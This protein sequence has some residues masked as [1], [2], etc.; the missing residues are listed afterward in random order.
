[1]TFSIQKAALEEWSNLLAR[2]VETPKNMHAA[3][4]ILSLSILSL[5][6]MFD[7]VRD[8]SLVDDEPV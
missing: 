5:L 3:C 6:F 8:Y 2:G 4:G 1:M 7:P